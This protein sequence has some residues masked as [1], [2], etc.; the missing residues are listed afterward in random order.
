MGDAPNT[1]LVDSNI[2]VYSVDVSEDTKQLRAIEVLSRLDL[3]QRGAVSA[4][5]LGESYNS[6][7]TRIAIPLAGPAAEAFVLGIAETWTVIDLDAG[8]VS[9]AIRISRR[10]Q[11]S[12]WDGLLFGAARLN[13]VSALLSE[14]MQDRQIVDGVRIMN[15]LDDSFDLA[16]LD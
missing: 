5:V 1:F 16:L 10:F 14:D 15:P 8:V 12:Y 4:Q 3:S 2:L 13:G 7:T 9:E 11:L 6:M